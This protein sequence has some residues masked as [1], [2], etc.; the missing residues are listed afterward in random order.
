MTVALRRPPQPVVRK[1]SLAVRGG[2]SHAIT[3]PGVTRDMI[4]RFVHDIT[5]AANTGAYLWAVTLAA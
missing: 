2:W 4:D 5:V 3:M 1:W